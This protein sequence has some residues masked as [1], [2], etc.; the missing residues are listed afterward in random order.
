MQLNKIIQTL[1]FTGVIIGIFASI[2]KNAYGFT[3]MGVSCFGL[4]GLYF[5]QF[6]WKLIE[7]H[8]ALTKNEKLWLAELLLLS[9][10]LTLF[11]FRAFY[12]YYPGSKLLFMVVCIF[13]V[14]VYLMLALEVFN[15]VK[16]D[17][18][19]FGLNILFFHLA[20]FFFL[21]SM[22]ARP[23][24]TLSIAL[25]ILGLVGSVPVI[26]AV[27]RKQRFEVQGETETLFDF[28]RKSKNKAGLLFMFFLVSGIYTGLSQFGIIPEIENSDRPKA[29]IDLINKAESGIEKAVDGK[30]RHQA[31]QEAMDRFLE[32][33]QK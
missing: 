7:D 12:I 21:T 28:V 22:A 17:N 13:L 10:M 5:M 29:Y 11:G 25:G 20:I 24:P 8:A 23:V 4:A 18:K 16:R 3:L 31:Y 6:I 14:V 27:L 9:I 26:L 32:R 2:S 15:T 19:G 30:Y 33:H 1:L